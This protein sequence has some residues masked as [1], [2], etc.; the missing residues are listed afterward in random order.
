MIGHAADA[1]RVH[2]LVHDGV[3]RGAGFLVVPLNALTDRSDLAAFRTGQARRRGSL[4]R[5]DVAPGSGV[6]Q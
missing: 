5:M 4:M 3:L 1:I 6:E 2:S